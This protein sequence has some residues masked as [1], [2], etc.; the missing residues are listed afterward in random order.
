MKKFLRKVILRYKSDS[1][2]FLN[3]YRAL[4]TRIGERTVVYEPTKTVIDTTRPWMITIGDDVKL[5]RGVTILTHGYDWSVLAGMNDVV[6]GS[7]GEV[8]IGNNVFVGMNTMILKGVH[9]GNNVVIG[10]NS[11][12]NK[13]IPDNCVAAGNPA[14][15]IMSIED[16]YEKRLKEQ[17]KEA[18]ALYRAYVENMK[19][20]P[21]V[22]AFDEF[23]WLFWKRDDE[24]LP[25]FKRQMSHHARFDE[26]YANFKNSQPEFNGYEA[27]L[28]A[29]RETLST[30]S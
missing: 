19:K 2:S 1:D 12:V 24:L 27:F 8:V 5:T 21:P 6:L 10:A 14:R 22:E 13:N 29:A 16:Y 26:T 28:E 15:V 20:E 17:K 25:C 18:F 4:G 3:H 7:A 11:L 9:I 23:F 30:Q